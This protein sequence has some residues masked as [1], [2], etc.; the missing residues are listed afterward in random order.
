VGVRLSS[1]VRSGHLPSSFSSRAMAAL[2]MRNRPSSTRRTR[3]HSAGV[4]RSRPAS[5]SRFDA[6]SSSVPSI[7]W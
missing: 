7:W 6:L 1:L 3:R 2:S 5:S 4:V